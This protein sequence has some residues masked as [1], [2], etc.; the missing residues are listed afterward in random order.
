DVDS[1]A[2]E[3]QHLGVKGSA[4]TFRK[5]SSLTAGLPLYVQ[6][7]LRLSKTHYR[8]DLAKLCSEVSEQSNVDET[9]QEIILSRLFNSLSEATRNVLAV[10]S[11]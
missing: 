2:A 1:I 6:S 8:G 10:W 4:N 9:A 5:L 7:A 3:A 11:L